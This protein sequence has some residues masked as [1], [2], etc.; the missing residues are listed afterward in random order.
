MNL[1]E[2]EFYPNRINSAI[3]D[4]LDQLLNNA[5]DV[6]GNNLVK[7]AT[8][9]LSNGMQDIISAMQPSP[10]GCPCVRTLGGQRQYPIAGVTFI[11]CDGFLIIPLY[12]IYHAID[13]PF[14][15]ELRDQHIDACIRWLEEPTDDPSENYG[16]SKA[17]SSD[18]F[19][20][21]K[22]WVCVIDHDTPLKYL[23]DVK[24]EPPYYCSRVDLAI[25]INEINARNDNDE[26]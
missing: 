15:E 10:E 23:R 19:F 3:K 25:Q 1:S 5:V 4:I 12:F 13:E 11:R 16:L 26:D 8:R 17:G 24:I 18:W 6:N 2:Y 21:V 20:K 7:S 22:E 14:F 9:I